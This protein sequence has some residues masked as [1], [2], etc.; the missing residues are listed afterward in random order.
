[1]QHAW[2]RQRLI[3]LIK[4]GELK[5]EF[6]ALYGCQRKNRLHLNLKDAN[7]NRIAD[8]MSVLAENLDLFALNCVNA[9]DRAVNES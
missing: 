8:K 2:E 4:V 1:M 6:Q 7:A 9:E 3:S 5:K